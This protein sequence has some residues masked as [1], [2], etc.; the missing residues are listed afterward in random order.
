MVRFLLLPEDEAE[1]L[2]WA[3]VEH[4]LE[5]ATSV[6]EASGLSRLERLTEY[7]VRFLANLFPA[8]L[9]LCQ[10]SSSCVALTGA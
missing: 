2:A 1:F 3:Q 5:F 10:M 4:G 6:A 8:P 9:L 7:L